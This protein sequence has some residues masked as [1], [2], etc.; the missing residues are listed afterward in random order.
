MDPNKKQIMQ[1][2]CNNSVPVNSTI[3]DFEGKVRYYI[4]E[5]THS[6]LKSWLLRQQHREEDGQNDSCLCHQSECCVIHSSES[7][8]HLQESQ[9]PWNGL[10]LTTNT[11]A[12]QEKSPPLFPEVEVTRSHCGY[13]SNLWQVHPN[14]GQLSGASH[15][16]SAR[17]IIQTTLGSSTSL[18]LTQIHSFLW[19]SNIP[20]YICTQGWDGWRGGRLKREMICV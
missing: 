16:C 19:L 1:H 13:L 20:L 15:I 10:P 2:S 18:E 5:D 3:L 6:S 8:A 7:A 11:P 9:E 12:W 17:G 14:G 4:P